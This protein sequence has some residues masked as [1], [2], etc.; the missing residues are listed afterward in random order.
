M[1]IEKLYRKLEDTL[2]VRM[3]DIKEEDLYQSAPKEF[4]LPNFPFEKTLD[5]ITND[6]DIFI[7][8]NDGED[9]IVHR[10]GLNALVR[11]HIHQDDV[12]GRLLSKVS[13]GFFEVL[14]EPLREV[15][16]TQNKVKLRFFYHYHEKLS[17]FSNVTIISDMGKLI[18]VSDHRANREHKLTTSDEDR[19]DEKANLIEYFSQTGSYYKINDKYTWTQ[20]IYNIINRGREENDE[21]YNIVFDLVIPTDRPLIEKILQILDNGQ[22]SY[23]AVIRIRTHDGTLK[24][25]EINLYSK[26][27]ENGNLISRYGLM[28]DVSTESNRK[29][30]RPV[31]YLLKGFKNSKRLALMIEP[32]NLKQYEFSEG[33][34]NIIE[35]D[36]S[37]YKHSRE[38]LANIVEEDVRNKLLQFIDGENDEINVNFTYNA[39]GDKNYQKSCEMYIERFEFG[40]EIH[41]IGFL[42]DITEEYTKQLELIEANEHQKV[43]IKEVHH[44]VKNNLQ[45]LNSFLNLEKRAYKDKPDIIIDHMQSRLSSLAILH[46]KTYNTTDFKNINLKEYIT[47]Q[48][49]QLRSLIGLRDGIEFVSEVDGDLNLTIEVITPLLLVIDELTMNAIKHAFPD[50]SMPNKKIYKRIKKLDNQTG[51]LTLKDNGVGIENPDKITKNLGCEIIKNLTKQLDGHIELYEHEIGTGYKLTF[52]LNMEHTIEG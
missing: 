36:P 11:G 17:R 1:R 51:E 50:K 13:P 2:E 5:S 39:H 15:Y 48:D 38:V 28:K 27:D 16:K 49:S 32:L 46:E 47:D 33:F 21:Y 52:P 19:Y 14:A 12:V 9:F 23:E 34:Y 18:L 42:T 3:Y 4:D 6:I 37:E 35:V 24:Y 22:T 8:H 26:F 45:V 7:P 30:T 31:D 43:L 25:I 41:S 44:R 40:T 29:I 10:L 20:G